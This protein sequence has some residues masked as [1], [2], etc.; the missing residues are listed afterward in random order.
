MPYFSSYPRANGSS[1]DRSA[2]SSALPLTI[3]TSSPLSRWITISGRPVML[4]AFREAGSL[5]N[6]TA[7]SC[8][9]PH[10]GMAWGRP[11]SLALTIQ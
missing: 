9:S 7:P 1:S 10:T 4:R 11:S 5:L 3:T 6:H 2:T 8:H